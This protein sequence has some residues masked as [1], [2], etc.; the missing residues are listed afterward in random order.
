MGREIS[1]EERERR[2]QWAL[3]KNQETVVEPDGTV[4]RKFGGPQPGSGRPRKPRASERIAERV[5][6]DGDTFY[7]KLKE[8]VDGKNPSEAR[9]AIE[10]LLNIEEKE[11]SLK[12]QE[13]RDIENMRR[14]QLMVYIKSKLEELGIELP[15]VIEGTATLVEPEE[16]PE[17]V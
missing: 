5:A 6:A 17:H 12:V 8:I 11:R 3:E 14:D 9:K 10:T 4:R 16:I 1:P 7:I 13:E 15:D 2:R